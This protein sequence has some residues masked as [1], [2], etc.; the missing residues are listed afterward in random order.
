MHFH[1]NIFVETINKVYTKIA[2]ASTNGACVL[3][4]LIQ[5]VPL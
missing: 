5:I 1:W 3:L 4:A 2:K